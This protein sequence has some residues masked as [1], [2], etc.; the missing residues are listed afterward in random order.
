MVRQLNIKLSKRHKIYYSQIFSALLFTF[1]FSSNIFSQIESKYNL[2]FCNINR[3]VFKWKF[4][5]LPENIQIDTSEIVNGKNPLC[6]AQQQRAIIHAFPLI[7]NFYQK[8]YLPETID[9]SDSIYI[10][11]H[12][13][14]FGLNKIKLNCFGLNIT[15]EIVY[16]DSIDINNDNYWEEKSLAFRV[17]DVNKILIGIVGVGFDFKFIGEQKFWIDRINISINKE[18]DIENFPLPLIRLQQINEDSIIRF[19]VDDEDS[20]EKL[21]FSAG[22]IIGLG[23]SIHGSKTINELQVQLIKNLIQK[24]NCRLVLFEMNTYELLMWNLFIQSKLPE[25]YMGNIKENITN[26]LFSVDALSCLLLW[27]RSYNETVDKKVRLHGL[28]DLF[29]NKENPLFDYLYS[30]VND[31]TVS[32]I[33][34]VLE[35][36]HKNKM[37]EAFVKV[38]N[39]DKLKQLMGKEEYYNFLFAL[40]RSIDS[41]R[42][43]GIVT[44]FQRIN[45]RDFSMWKNADWFL[46]SYKND[47]ETAVIIGYDSHINKKSSENLFPYVYSLGYYLDQ[48]YTNKYCPLGIYVAKGTFTSK[49]VDGKLTDFSL[50]PPRKESLECLGEKVGSPCFF[51]PSKFLSDS[52]VFFRCIANMYI[53]DNYFY[54]SLKQQ[55]VQNINK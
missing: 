2:N 19:S 28:L 3:D 38:E 43:K 1:F 22:K 16:Q 52:D 23:E 49:S 26:N 39:S 21:E 25:D 53:G 10:S 44:E 6:M 9:N 30:F 40:K 46:S 7:L 35:E 24:Y 14:C 37:K 31:N 51:Y 45:S 29:Y 48:K 15:D 5:A 18:I 54:G 34:P 55:F 41:S 50:P 4:S 20:L 17:M 32:Y 13:K 33:Y 42:F 47:N 11:I 12:N 27:L 36:I 8:I